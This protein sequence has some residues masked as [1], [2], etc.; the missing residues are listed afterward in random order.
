MER[1]TSTRL[2]PTRGLWELRSK[3]RIC[4]PLQRIARCAS[5][6]RAF[7]SA[8]SYIRARKGAHLDHRAHSW[9]KAF[10]RRRRGGRNTPECR[11]VGVDNMWCRTVSR[12]DRR[13]QN[14]LL[15]HVRERPWKHE[16]GFRQQN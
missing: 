11:R 8:Y 4:L 16:T 7:Q 2:L 14:E 9:R 1:N 13:A 5:R 3:T 6:Q 12:L 10:T 15:Q